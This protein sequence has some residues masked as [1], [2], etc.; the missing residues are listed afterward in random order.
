MADYQEYKS[1]GAY[2]GRI[3]VII[4]GFVVLVLAVWFVIGIARD[5]K[6]AEEKPAESS[7]V[8]QNNETPQGLQDEVKP[9]ENNQPSTQDDAPV[10][11]TTDE[12]EAE[13]EPSTDA[14]AEEETGSTLGT[15]TESLPN[16]GISTNIALMIALP[17]LTFAGVKYID[18]RNAK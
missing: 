3:L 9:E 11:D 7:E 10:G 2:L 4:V 15:N 13:Q 16:T 8:A 12:A 14:P 6:S 17:V 1:Y 18:S 5:D